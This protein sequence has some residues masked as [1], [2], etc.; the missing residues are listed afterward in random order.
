MSGQGGPPAPG[1]VPRAKSAPEAPGLAV[2]VH[3]EA[4]VDDPEGLAGALEATGA[5][6][7]VIDGGRVYASFRKPPSERTVRDVA[8]R[9]R[10]HRP[11]LKAPTEGSR[12]AEPHQ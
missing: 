1:G 5:E 11:A 4:T 10:A 3:L 9:A 8:D 6:G 12:D 2:L 7:V